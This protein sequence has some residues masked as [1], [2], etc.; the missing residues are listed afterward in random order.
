MTELKITCQQVKIGY[1]IKL[2][3]GWLKHPFLSS[4]LVVENQQQIDII[5]SL[6]L[7]FV[8]F[9]PEQS[10]K[11]PA[12]PAS[13]AKAT[14]PDEP[15]DDA[16]N[17]ASLAEAM[18]QLQQDKAQRIEAGK[19]RRQAL[20]RTEKAYEQSIGSVKDC[21]KQL[22]SRPIEAVEQ[23]QV[24]INGMADSICNAESLMIQLIGNKKA[25]QQ[26][27]HTH[28]LNV[29]VLSMLLGQRI[30]HPAQEVELL[31]M[32]ALFHDLGKVRIPMQIQRKKDV[33]SKAEQGLMRMHPKYGLDLVKLIDVFPSGAKAMISQHHENYRGTGYPQGLVGDAID[34]LAQIVGLVNH[35][36]NLCHPVDESKA[37]SPHHALSFMFGPS[38]DLYR[39]DLLEVFIRLMGIYP[40]G[41]LVQLSD[42]RSGMV[43]AT[44]A[45][46]LAK[47]Q[48]LCYDP[49]V[50][51]LEAPIIH[52][53]E[54]VSIVKAVNSKQLSPEILHYLNPSS[55]QSY[56]FDGQ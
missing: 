22:Q 53:D 33:L 37:L 51:S 31:G 6:K 24:L 45:D 9:Y 2:P 43:L 19:V 28:S 13:T 26:D 36:D 17:T 23:A 32:G 39:K 49:D 1:A 27:T 30:G 18:Q 21:L 10:V 15:T 48:V 56:Y 41:S 7:E 8:Y 34:P 11:A 47:P 20:Q 4:Q 55:Q 46:N 14:E 5:N 38:R 42:G 29:A 12:A 35:F 25:E 3:C 50:P 52:L 16:A 40:P 44:N 54:R